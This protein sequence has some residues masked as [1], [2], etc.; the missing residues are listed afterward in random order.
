MTERLRQLL[1]EAE[2][3]PEPLALAGI[4]DRVRRARRVRAGTAAAV[5]AVVAAAIAIPLAVIPGPSHQAVLTATPSH[6]GTAAG[7]SHPATIMV[8]GS[9]VPYVGTVPWSDAVTPSPDSTTLTI[10]ADGDKIGNG[11][12]GLP[13]ERIEVHQDADSVQV[14]VAGYAQPFPPGVACAGTAH[15]LQPH[16]IQLTAP[17]G[18]RRLLDAA[19]NTMHKALTAS[20]VPTLAEVPAGYQQQPVTWNEQTGQINRSWRVPPAPALADSP[21]ITLTQAPAGVIESQDPTPKGPEGA[22][23]ATGVPVANG[24]AQA[25][26]WDYSNNDQRLI[27]VRWT[28]AD[29]LDHQLAT[30]APPARSLSPAQTEALA[31]SVH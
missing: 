25:R 23:I 12:C 1:R 19:N 24:T 31:R 9:I 15:R 4:R 6:P 28:S 7:I 27:T 13:T 2:P 5:A 26:V 10:Y 16:Q 18:A 29:G 17:L 20:S 30:S 3:E 8:G 22:L 11:V 14:Q 21:S